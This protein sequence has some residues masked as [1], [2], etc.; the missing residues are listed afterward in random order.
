MAQKPNNN[1]NNINLSQQYVTFSPNLHIVI[2]NQSRRHAKCH[3]I[4]VGEARKMVHIRLTS[5]PNTGKTVSLLKSHIQTTPQIPTHHTNTYTT[6]LKQP[7]HN[8]KTTTNHNI[9]TPQNTK[10]TTTHPIHPP[11][12][13]TKRANLSRPNNENKYKKRPNN[14]HPHLHQ[15]HRKQPPKHK[16]TQHHTK[17]QPKPRRQNALNTNRNTNNKR[18]LK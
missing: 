13:Q 7:T 2:N 11:L 1:N 4:V 3:G 6:N 5:G 15:H 17:K 10:P 14:H 12:E 9:Y 16:T 8:T 18:Y